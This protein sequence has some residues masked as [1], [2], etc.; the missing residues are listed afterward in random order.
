VRCACIDIGSNTT[1]L[2]VADRGEAGLREVL[3]ERVFTRLGATDEPIP[4]HKVAALAATVAAQARAARAA[5]AQDVCAVATA[6]IRRAPNREALCAAVSAAAGIPL[7]VLSGEQEARLAFLGATWGIADP[8]AGPVA[9]VDIGGGSSEVACGVPGGEV[10]YWASLPI[11]SASLTAGWLPGDPPGPGELE[12]AREHAVAAFAGLAPPAPVV[13]AYAVGGSATSLRRL[14]GEI[15]DAES[16]RRALDLV[17]AEPAEV[18]ARTLG[19]HVERTRI[20]AAGLIL[21]EVGN[22]VLGVPLRVVPGG[23]REGLLLE[24]SGATSEAVKKNRNIP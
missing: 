14:V 20:L 9:V 10:A 7:T 23:L 15:L 4:E 17:C 13:A 16:L 8:P 22:L 2:L 21:L 24:R 19:L 3:S 11:G 18:T 1:R 5:G 6:A 12:R